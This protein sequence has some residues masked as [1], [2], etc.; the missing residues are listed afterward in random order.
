[1]NH[2]K[3]LKR[4]LPRIFII[5]GKTGGGKSTFLSQ[6][7]S[8]LQEAQIRIGG[9]IADKHSTENHDYF[10]ELRDV[11]SGKSIPLSSKNYT[12]GW[13]RIGKF[14][15][16]PGAIAFWSDLLSGL[17]NKSADLIVIDEIGPFE[18]EDMMW[19][20]AISYLLAATD[21][22]MIWVVRT[23]LVEPVLNK[24]R[25]SK[26]VIID[27]NKDSV[28]QAVKQILSKLAANH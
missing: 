28:S 2:Y 16:N 13:I 8:A 3:N 15:F 10:Y 26:P 14:Y 18:L 23:G 22:P 9:F 5:T 12:E 21:L 11:Q 7:V 17:K 27:I 19:A 6:I 25:I 20:G 1:M 4:P 24:W